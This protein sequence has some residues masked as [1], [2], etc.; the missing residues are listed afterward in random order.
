MHAVLPDDRVH[1]QITQNRQRKRIVGR[2]NQASFNRKKCFKKY[3]E[4]LQE[5]WLMVGGVKYF[6]L[7]FFQFQ[8][9]WPGPGNTVCMS[10]VQKLAY[11]ENH[12]RNTNVQWPEEGYSSLDNL[13]PSFLVY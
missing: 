2:E 11:Y 10:Q 4:H 9:I 5:N 3:V 13:F 1:G 8:E 7:W 12:C 6:W